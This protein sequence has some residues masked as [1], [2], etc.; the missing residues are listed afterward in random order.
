[1]VRSRGP[2][3]STIVH[4]THISNLQSTIFAKQ[5]VAPNDMLIIFKYIFYPRKGE[6]SNCHLYC[7]LDVAKFSR[8]HHPT[9]L[10]FHK[11]HYCSTP[12]FYWY[13]VYHQNSSLMFTNPMIYHQPF[14]NIITY[15]LYHPS[16]WFFNGATIHR[17]S[18]AFLH[19][20]GGI[21]TSHDG[22]DA[23]LARDDGGVAGTA[24]A[25][26][27][28]GTSLFPRFSWWILGISPIKVITPQWIIR[29]SQS[30]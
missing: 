19:L 12:L 17:W 10:Q 14:V 6:N 21:A 29:S 23:Q 26:G 11:P 9:G 7:G 25:V 24:T 5:V 27:D 2:R 16:P 28:D 22:R 8:F 13:V 20:V 30:R 1:M 18:P 3:T 15:N 4:A